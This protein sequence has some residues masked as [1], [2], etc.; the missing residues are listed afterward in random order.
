MNGAALA[1]SRE[2]ASNRAA[3]GWLF[4]V[5]VPQAIGP[6]A[7]GSPSDFFHLIGLSSVFPRPRRNAPNF[8]DPPIR[9]EPC[10]LVVYFAVSSCPIRIP[11][12]G[13]A[14]N[15]SIFSNVYQ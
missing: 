8:W 13:S 9:N 1:A 12:A 6:Q 11:L 4:V 5:A 2:A 3:A 7:A 10:F 14:R 15:S